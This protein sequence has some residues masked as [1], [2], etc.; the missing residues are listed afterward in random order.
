MRAL[1]K[2]KTYYRQQAVLE[3][4]LEKDDEIRAMRVILKTLGKLP[5][6]AARRV[7]RYVF[8]RQPDALAV[9]AQ[10]VPPPLAPGR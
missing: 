7:L 1:R 4:V 8:E 6:D 9:S 3:D 10:A 2:L 5:P